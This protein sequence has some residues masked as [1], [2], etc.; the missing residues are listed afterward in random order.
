R[1]SARGGRR[2]GPG[3]T[4][5]L[6]GRSGGTQQPFGQLI[7]DWGG[8]ERKGTLRFEGTRFRRRSRDGQSP[9][10]RPDQRLSGA[11]T[12]TPNGSP[13]SPGEGSKLADI[14]IVCRPHGQ[15]REAAT[16]DDQPPTGLKDDL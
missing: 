12:V 2:S 5:R 13:R 1:V 14:V 8:W 10:D 15:P 9:Q 11:A 6:A 16:S 7:A 3:W 4:D